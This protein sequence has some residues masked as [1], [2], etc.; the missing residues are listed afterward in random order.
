[1]LR[2]TSRQRYNL[3]RRDTSD[4]ERKSLLLS[5]N[6]GSKSILVG[7]IDGGGGDPGICYEDM[8]EECEPGGV[9]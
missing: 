7:M 6:Q 9:S 1:M 8:S 2:L 4:L 5:R 3:H